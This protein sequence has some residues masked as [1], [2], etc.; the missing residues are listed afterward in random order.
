MHRR[1]IGRDVRQYPEVVWAKEQSTAEVH[2][3][4]ECSLKSEAEG[5]AW[6]THDTSLLLGSIW[7]WVH[8][9]ASHWVFKYSAGFTQFQII[10]GDLDD[11][12][13]FEWDTNNIAK[14][15]TFELRFKTYC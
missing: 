8:C 5:F 2:H 7:I 14:K 6:G 1:G 9:S 12:N 15:G 11:W 10:H 13:V 3:P 4:M